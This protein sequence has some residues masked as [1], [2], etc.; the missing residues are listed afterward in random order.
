MR[1]LHNW[2]DAYC[3]Y[4]R[5]TESAPIFHKWV[6]LSLL[7]G[8]LRKKVWLSL[9]RIKIFPNLYIVLVAEPGVSR[10]SQ[11][12]SY[13]VDLL[14]EVPNIVV[15]SDTIT[16]EA[17]LQDLE[18]GAVDDL[19]PD[20]AMFRHASLNIISKEFESF[21]GQKG[22]NTK[23]L[24]LLTDLYDSQEIPFKYRTKNSGSNTVP[25]VYLNLLGA[26]TPESLASCLP[27]SAIGGGL[28]SRILFIWSSCKTKKVAIPTITPEIKQLRSH[29]IH[30]L[31]I[32][33]RMAGN[34]QFSSECKE[35][36]VQWYEGYDE[37][38]TGRICSDPAF[39]GWYSRK[40]MFL[41]KIAQALSATES[42][43]MTL[44]WKY[45]ERALDIVE[46]AELAMGR[47]FT[48]VGKSDIATEVDSVMAIIRRYKVI[49]EKQVM[50]MVWRD[51]DSSKFENVIATATKTGLFERRFKGPEGQSGIWY[52]YKGEDE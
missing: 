5:E 20:N 37:T 17:L 19:M 27:P 21:L 3:E 7:A 32:I 15:S 4:T 39:N 43:N 35:N 18:G 42:N 24:V 13:G 33:S 46:E 8:V 12:I 23:M 40:P 16:K 50:Q 52:Y 2:L 26:T 14:N 6:G 25:S 49:S 22:E 48:A 29:L 36:W 1:K 10:K 41:Q 31:T 11:S 38:S 47:T 44:E 9:G 51:I 45:F 30:D 28:T 34:F